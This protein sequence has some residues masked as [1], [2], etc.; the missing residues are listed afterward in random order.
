VAA[1]QPARLKRIGYLNPGVRNPST[2]VFLNGLRECGWIEEKNILIEWRF[3]AG[4]FG[5]LK[6][7]AAEFERLKLDVVVTATSAATQAMQD[8]TKTVPIVFLA[9]GDPVGQGFVKS[10]SHP[11]GNITG[12]SFDATADIT[13]KQVQL[14]I[15]MVPGIDRVA[16]L[17][18]PASPF[19][20][21]YWEAARARGPDL[22]VALD[23]FEVQESRQFESTFDAIKS[24][25]AGALIVLSDSFFTF[26]GSRIAELAA[27][28]RIPT[29]YGH[30]RYI[31]EGGGLMSY[32]PSLSDISRRAASYVDKIL[33]DAVPADLPVEQP[34]KFDLIINLKAAKALALNVPQA[35]LAR[36][37]EV[38]E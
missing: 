19:L 11:G 14:L 27:K 1:Q 16:V 38:I 30:S 36:A 18:N 28:Y 33:K 9:A 6:A 3:A 13:A 10:L 25:H 12:V 20:R 2:E 31:F 26:H 22:G 23:S 34:I 17:W 8:V 4:D 29:I 15:E 7:F 24:A 32:G 37:D 35:L 5:K 21:S